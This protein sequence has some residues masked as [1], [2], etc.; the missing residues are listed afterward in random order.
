MSEALQAS[1]ASLAALPVRGCWNCGDIEGAPAKKR[2]HGPKHQHMITHIKTH[3]NMLNFETYKTILYYTILIYSIQYTS[4]CSIYIQKEHSDK[5]RRPNG[6]KSLVLLGGERQ[7]SSR[8]GFVA[9]R[10][11]SKSIQI[12]WGH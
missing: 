1:P 12:E 5:R 6:L 3:Q 4:V 7:S 8:Q 2:K 10:S 11:K 9:V